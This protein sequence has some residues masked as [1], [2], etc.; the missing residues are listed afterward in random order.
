M[1]MLLVGLVVVACAAIGAALVWQLALRDTARPI[2]LDEA[3]GRF[4]EQAARNEGRIPA[5]VYVYAT[6]G[7]ESVSAL[8]G[9]RHRYPARSTITVTAAGCGVVLRWDV[10]TTR[11]NTLTLCPRGQAL[12]LSAWSEQ[13]EFFGRTDRTDWRCAATP[14]LPAERSPGSASRLV[15]RSKDSTQTGTVSVVGTET[16]TVGSTRVRAVRVRAESE[17]AGGASGT[18]VD[19]HWLEPET[20]LPLRVAYRVRTVNPSPIGDVTFEERYDLRLVSLA[21]RR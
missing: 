15:C 6:S 7:F 9:V 18:L 4:R 14:W 19:E 8:G 10:L 21:P 3:L 1:R 20:G 17:E 11:W 2:T 12:L 16:V 5:G 13:H